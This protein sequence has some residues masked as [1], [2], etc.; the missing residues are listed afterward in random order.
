MLWGGGGGGEEERGGVWGVGGGGDWLEGR[1]RKRDGE[2]ERGS[3]NYREVANQKGW[4]G[5]EGQM[6]D[7]NKTGKRQTEVQ[8]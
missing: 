3:V 8:R 4:D 6:T 2:R 7:E 5:R 1:W